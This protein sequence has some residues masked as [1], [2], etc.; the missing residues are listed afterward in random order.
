MHIM[1]NV[2]DD[3]IAVVEMMTSLLRWHEFRHQS[4][5]S[6]SD[7]ISQQTVAAPSI[8]FVSGSLPDDGMQQVINKLQ[9][10]NTSWGIVMACPGVDDVRIDQAMNAGARGVLEKPLSGDQ[11]LK[12]I[13]ETLASPMITYHRAQPQP[14]DIGHQLT[15]EEQQIL[16]LIKEGIAIKQIASRLDIS[17]RTIHYRKAAIL[18]KTGCKNC[19]EV[20]AKLSQMSTQ[21][22]TQPTA[23]ITGPLYHSELY[24]GG[25]AR[26]SLM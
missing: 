8:T 18:E 26:L 10:S 9:P 7:F 12:T 11:V 2:V 20:I 21:D 19:I 3:D 13:K 25:E 4:F 14:T 5:P 6:A 22:S 16:S 23:L 17:V 24:P 15:F 1:I